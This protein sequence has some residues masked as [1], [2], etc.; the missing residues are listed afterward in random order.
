MKKENGP[1][2]TVI[3]ENHGVTRVCQ[4]LGGEWVPCER[5]FECVVEKRVNVPS[6]ERAFPSATAFS[7]VTVRAVVRLSGPSSPFL[8]ACLPACLLETCARG[9]ELRFTSQQRPR[10]GREKEEK[11]A[12]KDCGDQVT[13]TNN[14]MV[15]QLTEEQIA[16]FKEAFSL[17]D[18]DGDG[19]Y[20][21]LFSDC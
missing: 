13:T 3:T 11:S 1:R 21:A 18:K 17:F 9:K 5:G 8:F 7:L 14:N 16:E 19:K 12:R 20:I 6:R 4:A 15:E 2:K 10:R